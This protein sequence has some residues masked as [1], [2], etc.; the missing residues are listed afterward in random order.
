MTVTYITTFYILQVPFGIVL[1]LLATGE[2]KNQWSILTLIIVTETHVQ[3]LQIYVSA[4]I[5]DI[6]FYIVKPV[7]FSYKWPSYLCKPYHT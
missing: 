2:A 1:S 4:N 7:F 6:R 3:S 5:V